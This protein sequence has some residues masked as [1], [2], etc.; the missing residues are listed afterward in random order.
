MGAAPELLGV[1]VLHA[2]RK[3]D[4]AGLIPAHRR[5]ELPT[6]IQALRIRKYRHAN[7]LEGIW[8]L[9]GNLAACDATYVALA[10]LLDAVLVTRDTRLA[11]APDLPARIVTP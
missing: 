6:L 2:L 8:S 5:N 7:L 1:E 4:Q 11:N 9:R 3:L 10:D